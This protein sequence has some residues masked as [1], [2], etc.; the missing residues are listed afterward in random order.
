[1]MRTIKIGSCVAI[2][3]LFVSD[4]NDGRIV[5]RVGAQT[6]VGHPV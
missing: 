3:G 1:M 4:S 6:Y 2:Q 5:V